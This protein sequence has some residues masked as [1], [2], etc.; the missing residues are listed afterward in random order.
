MW[1]W[2]CRIR[3]RAMFI[4]F[5][6]PERNPRDSCVQQNT[7]Y[8]RTYVSIH[9][10]IVLSRTVLTVLLAVIVIDTGIFMAC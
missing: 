10:C 3:Y 4:Y 6:M 9:V 5:G 8:S 2:C 1:Y 7:I